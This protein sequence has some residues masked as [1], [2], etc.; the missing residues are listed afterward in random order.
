[1]PSFG[2][3]RRA[4]LVG[5][6]TGLL[7]AAGAV[8]G[9]KGPDDEKEVSAVEDMMREHGVLRRA[10]L[11]Y[12]ETAARLRAEAGAIDPKLLNETALLFQA[13]GENYHER[14]LEE[15]YVFPAV[16]KAGGAAAAL[17]DIL[18][19][20]HNRGREITEYVLRVT[21]KASISAAD[22]EPLA[23]ALE[24]Q[25]LM[26]QNH[27]AREDTVVF[28]AWKNAL[29]ESQLDELGE[30]FEEIEH[31]QFGADGFEDAVRKIAAIEQ[32]L[33]YADLSQFTAPSPPR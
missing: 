8:A 1:M 18:T 7:F 2:R 31:K 23:R 30:K 14:E 13:F 20:Q 5:G 29:S 19:A 17:P 11:V 32:A 3:D 22:A 15:P 33:G 16:R 12:A 28:P 4:L 9:P 24:A 10:L 21:G 6:A 27:A 25:A 26:Y